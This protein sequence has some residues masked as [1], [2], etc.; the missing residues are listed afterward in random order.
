MGPLV[1][2]S[3]SFEEN[4]GRKWK[5]LYEIEKK[6]RVAFEAE[7][8]AEREKFENEIDFQI[9]EYEANR[10]REGKVFFGLIIFEIISK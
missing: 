6:R 10:I 3:N 9:Q 7:L 5:E 2:K 8:K 1:A 4:I